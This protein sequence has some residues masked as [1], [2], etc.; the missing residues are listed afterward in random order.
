M[1]EFDPCLQARADL[2]FVITA[3][4]KD[5]TLKLR[6]LGCTQHTE[7]ASI[8]MRRAKTVLEHLT[9]HGVLRQQL[10]PERCPPPVVNGLVEYGVCAARFA[11][12]QSILFPK[13]LTFAEHSADLPANALTMLEKVVRTLDAHPSLALHIEG[14]ADSREPQ[15]QELSGQRAAAVKKWLR[16]NGARCSIGVVPCGRMCPVA[17]NLTAQGRRHNRRI[18]LQIRGT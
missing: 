12:V 1:C 18:E 4:K 8:A 6:V 2:A 5:R 14:H 9:G 3:L 11:V 10:R 15:P 13:R 7:A 17:P 16:D